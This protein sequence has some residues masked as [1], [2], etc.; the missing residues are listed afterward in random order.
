MGII[1]DETSWLSSTAALAQQKVSQ[2]VNGIVRSCGSKMG[3]CVHPDG[4]SIGS[5]IGDM[6]DEPRQW[7]AFE[8]ADLM[9][10]GRSGGIAASFLEVLEEETRLCVNRSPDKKELLLV[11]YDGDS[12]L[13]ARQSDNGEG[14]N[15]FV[16][17]DGEPPRSLG[18]AFTLKCNTAKDKWV[19]S[20]DMCDQCQCRGRRLCGSRELAYINHHIQQVEEDRSGEAKIMVLDMEIPETSQGVTD[21]WCS[22]CK[23][24]DTEQKFVELTTRRPKWNTRQKTL[25]MD[26]FGRC[27][28]ASAKNFQLEESG[29]S[30]G[31]AETV[32]LLFGKASESQ[33]VLDF[34]QPLSPIQAFAAALS[35]M[36]WK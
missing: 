19:L 27:R 8:H 15:I 35:T 14:F 21:V 32:K 5:K 29:K 1:G 7:S 36:V 12:L 23:G 30:D 24:H 3:R 4:V 20:A 31:K 17:G 26:F 18:P 28:M 11:N 2:Q 13:L 34:Q 22:M 16:T 33:F 25:T 10:Q 9:E 6:P